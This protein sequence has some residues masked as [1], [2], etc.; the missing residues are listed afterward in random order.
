MKRNHYFFVLLLLAGL[1]ASCKKSDIA[2]ES[3]FARSYKTYTAFKS[4]T[5][6]SYRYQVNTASWTGHSTETIITVKNG[7]VVKR[8]YVAKNISGGPTP[9]IVVVEQ[10]IEEE[11]SL[12]THANGAATLTL[13]QIYEKAR[14]VWLLK[15][16][17]AKTSLETKNN[18]MISSCGYVEDNCADDCFNGISIAF[19]ERLPN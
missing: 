19:I 5:N 10:W 15:R 3:D 2:F 17:G 12:N 18:G 9:Q 6:D 14:T 13:D 16:K 8:A 11:G 1:F 4:S 7:K